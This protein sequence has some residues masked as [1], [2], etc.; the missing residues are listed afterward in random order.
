MKYKYI[1]FAISLLVIIPGL[2]FL[3][4]YGLKLSI[5]FTGGSVIEVNNYEAVKNN[6]AKNN[7]AIISVQKTSNNSYVIRTKPI[8]T[9]TKNKIFG[10][11]KVE[12]FETVGPVIGKE[13]TINSIEAIGVA[14]VAIVLY[15]AYAFR[16]IP[17]PYKSWKFGVSAVV[18]LLH[19]VLVVI[20]IFAILGYFLGVEV[21]ALFVTAL[22]TIIGFSVHDTIVVFDRVRENLRKDASKMSFEDVVN[23]SLLQT[24]GRSLTTSLTVLFTLF[25]LVLFGGESIRWFCVALFVGI[26]SGT[27]SSI[28]NAAPLLVIWEERDKKN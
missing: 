16:E 8:D 12:R 5:D 20:G 19:D 7:V 28:F 18:A 26:A 11:T 14:S 15:I 27:Y 23:E 3:A 25:A 9:A 21:D 24:L 10:T 1:Y 17:K 4:R 6:F 2:Y 22:L 13:L